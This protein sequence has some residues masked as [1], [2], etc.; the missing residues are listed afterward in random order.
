MQ[1]QPLQVRAS[2]KT[3]FCS[4]FLMT[5]IV[6]TVISRP[7][8]PKRQRATYYSTQWRL[9]S[10]IRKGTKSS[11]RSFT[12]EIIVSIKNDFVLLCGV[13]KGKLAV[14]KK[15]LDSWLTYRDI[16]PKHFTMCR[17]CVRYFLDISSVLFIPFLHCFHYNPF[18]FSIDKRN[19][20]FIMTV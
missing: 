4:W 6:G 19:K 1:P 18:R 5:F 10:E 9:E 8:W 20:M 15:F 2:I 13:G 7:G 16:Y 17:V 12:A 14:R 3:L 11:S